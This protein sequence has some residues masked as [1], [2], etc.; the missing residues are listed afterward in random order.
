MNKLDN[1]KLEKVAPVISEFDGKIVEIKINLNDDVVEGQVI[2]IIESFN[3]YLKIPSS[4]YGIVQ[5]I[6]VKNGQSIKKGQILAS[7]MKQT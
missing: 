5:N 1:E 4:V 7:I 6:L 3:I 2:M